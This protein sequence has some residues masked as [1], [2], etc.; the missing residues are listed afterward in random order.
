MATQSFGEATALAGNVVHSLHLGNQR[1]SEPLS[2]VLAEA[3]IP[4]V[5]GFDSFASIDLPLDPVAEGAR[6]LGHVAMALDGDGPW[7]R[8]LLL[9]GYEGRLLPSLALSS[10]LASKGASL[11]SLQVTGRRLQIETAEIP[12]D[13]DWRLP[14][15]FNGGPGTYTQY[16]YG[17]LFYSELQIREGQEPGLD[18]ALF[19]DKIV[20]VGLSAAGLHDIF[21]TPYSG[22]RGE[23][24]EGLGKMHGFEIHANVIDDLLHGRFLRQAPALAASGD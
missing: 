4:A 18:P 20:I 1:T 12:L 9:A 22:G 13:S 11:D 2:D 17:Q 15:W 24:G 10:A 7:R 8:Y 3:S 6:G 19:A 16:P 5:G 23:Q 21:T 14:I